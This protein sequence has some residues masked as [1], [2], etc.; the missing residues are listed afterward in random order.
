M[1]TYSVAARRVDAHGSL[2]TARAAEIV[3]DTGLAGRPD[4]FNPAE[5]LL[6]GSS[7][8]ISHKRGCVG[9]CFLFVPVV[10]Y[11]VTGPSPPG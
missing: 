1:Q 9:K 11:R 8:R 5:L 6:A 4:A 7:R 2:A 3:L 10:D